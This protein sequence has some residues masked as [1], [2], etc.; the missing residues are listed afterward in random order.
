VLLHSPSV[1]FVLGCQRSGTTLLNHILGSHPDMQML[2]HDAYRRVGKDRRAVVDDIIN[3]FESRYC[4]VKGPQLVL[5]YSWL[6]EVLPD[7]KIIWIFRDPLETVASMMSLRLPDYVNGKV[8]ELPWIHFF[9]KQEGTI[10]G[11]SEMEKC[12]NIWLMKNQACLSYDACFVHYRDLCYEPEKIIR[13]LCEYSGLPFHKQMLAHN[14]VKVEEKPIGGY[15][16]TLAVHKNEKRIDESLEAIRPK[17][18]YLYQQLLHHENR[19]C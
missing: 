11:E 6:K 1:I 3:R 12:A 10:D 13:K 14:E 15:D 4:C 9:E 7:A 19:V 18:N 5:H 17:T 8:V 2:D 16:P